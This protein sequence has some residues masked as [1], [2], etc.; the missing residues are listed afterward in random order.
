[1]LWDTTS[2]TQEAFDDYILA[3]IKRYAELVQQLPASES[4]HHSYAGG[5]SPVRGASAMIVPEL[6]PLSFSDS[7]VLSMSP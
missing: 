7:F 2:L 5:S 1:M 6:S 4:H 3:P